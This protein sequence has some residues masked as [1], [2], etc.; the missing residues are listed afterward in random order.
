MLVDS[1]G[2]QITYLRVSV[3]DRCNLRC[4]YCMPPEGVVWQPHEKIMHFEEIEKVIRV[5]AE[6]GVNEVR[7]TGGEPLVR[8]DLP[9][10][11]EI[12]ARIP[13]IEDI[14]LTTNGV[15][16]EKFAQPL[17]AAGLKR[18]NVSLD[19]LR[20][21]RF[22]AI[23]R[24]GIFRQV[25]RGLEI[26]QAVGLNPIKINTVI[27]RGVNEDELLDIARLSLE[28]PW[29][30]R[31]IELMPV[32][33]QADWGE[34]FTP[35]DEVY[36]SIPEMMEGLKPLGL[37][38]LTETIGSGPAEEFSVPGA[39]GTVGFIS[40]MSDKFCEKCNRL[41]LTADGHLRPCLLVDT[42]VPVLET[43]RAGGEILPLLQ[44]AADLK[45]AGHEIAELNLPKRRCM[46]QIGG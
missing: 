5:A 13:G 16:L 21:D 12:I 28:R 30:I 41:R 34:G 31:F 11:V 8:S 20:P 36:L 9:R 43:L 40:P 25:W 2:R 7:L 23:T 37:Q 4:V 24:G 10:L 26:S 39:P 15:L 19:T 38:P 46:L 17:V 6:Q 27:M 14:S 45:P 33:N 42:E 18:I 1:F 35:R 29:H 44:Q 22:A 32:N 3:T